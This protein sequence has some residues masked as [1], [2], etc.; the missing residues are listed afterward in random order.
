MTRQAPMAGTGPHTAW[1]RHARQRRGGQGRR[2]SLHRE[3][4]PSIQ[5]SI[6]MESGGIVST[7]FLSPR[8]IA[9]STRPLFVAL[10]N[11][12]NARNRVPGRFAVLDRDMFYEAV[13]PAAFLPSLRNNQAARDEALKI[14]FR[15]GVGIFES[16]A[17]AIEGLARKDWSAHDALCFVDELYTRGFVYNDDWL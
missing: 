1:H 8:R 3:H 17:I 16:I 13:V 12:M 11:E 2:R 14:L 9:P 4:G 5:I 7:T 15:N 6:N 10:A